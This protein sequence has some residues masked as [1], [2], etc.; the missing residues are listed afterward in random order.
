MIKYLHTDNKKVVK[1][2]FLNGV[3]PLVGQFARNNSFFLKTSPI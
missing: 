1:S 3:V 2:C